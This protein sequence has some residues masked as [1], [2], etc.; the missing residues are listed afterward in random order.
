MALA[1]S[2]PSGYS[3][4]VLAFNVAEPAN[5]VTDPT[6]GTDVDPQLEGQV[7]R[8]NLSWHYG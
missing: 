2:M 3:A 8:G 1:Q 4:E 5:S 7:S 6:T